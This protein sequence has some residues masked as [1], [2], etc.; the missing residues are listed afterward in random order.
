MRAVTAK[1]VANLI[2][3]EG[4]RLNNLNKSIIQEVWQ[5]IFNAVKEGETSCIFYYLPS[6]VHWALQ[7]QGYKIELEI[8]DDI[9][10]HV[11]YWH[12]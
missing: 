10:F 8:E 2:K 11:V 7:T 12:N 1:F 3:D 6:N 5:K 9:R 4:F